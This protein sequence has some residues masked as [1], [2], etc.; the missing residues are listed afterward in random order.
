MPLFEIQ[1]GG[2][3]QEADSKSQ[4]VP[5]AVVLQHVGPLLHVAVAVH[6]QHAERLIT[7]GQ[8]PPEAVTGLALID[9]GAS[10]TAVDEAVC[11]KLG[12]TPTS[13]VPMS[14]AGGSEQR[15][16]YSIQIL[17]PGAPLPPITIPLAASC[18]LSA[19]LQPYIVLLGRN[20]LARM[21][22]VYNG[23]RGRIE[24]AF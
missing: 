18:N 15:N 1:Y 9:T 8:Q 17:F 13:V 5:P 19:G 22:M 2:K 21:K 11:R 6:P 10:I 4:V 7:Q 12:L 24:I 23:P 16:C 20:L 3:A 14:H